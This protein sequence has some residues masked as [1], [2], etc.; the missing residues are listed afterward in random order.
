MLTPLERVAGPEA[1]VIGRDGVQIRKDGRVAV[2][3]PQVP[4]EQG[5][6]RASLLE[7][8][9]LKAGLPKDAWRSGAEFWTF[10]SVVFRE[11]APR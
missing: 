8:L 9:C 4:V 7:N 10:R 11:S 5:W 6:D 2:F 1:V 3:L